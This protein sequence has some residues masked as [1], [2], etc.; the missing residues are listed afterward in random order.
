MTTNRAEVIGKIK[1]AFYEL[2]QLQNSA[3]SLD[4]RAKGIHAGED[5]AVK[6][7]CERHGYGAV[8]DSAARQWH[9]QTPGSGHTTYHCYS[10]V[11]SVTKDA[12][13]AL[14]LLTTLQ[15]EKTEGEVS[16]QDIRD[17]CEPIIAHEYVWEDAAD[18]IS[19][20]LRAKFSITPKR[21]G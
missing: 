21:E 20:A 5:A 3:L 19:K 6:E 12:K 13:K 18:K 1:D 16:D 11:K 15:H 4:I 8:M 14:T 17:I 10:V 9:L 7:L 2:I